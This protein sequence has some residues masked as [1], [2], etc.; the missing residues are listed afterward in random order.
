MKTYE[1]ERFKNKSD[2]K[3]FHTKFLGGT[4]AGVLLGVSKYKTKLDLYEEIV[5]NNTNENEIINENIT[6]GLKSEPLIRKMFALHFDNYKVRNPKGWECYI[7]K[8][9]P[10]LGATIDGELTDKETKEKGIL[11]IKTCDIRRKKDIEEWEKNIPMQYYCQVIHYLMIRTDCSF[12]KLVA[13]LRFFDWFV[14]LANKVTKL[15]T[16]IYHIERADVEEDIKKLKKLEIDF[17]KNNI[18][19]RIPPTFTRKIGG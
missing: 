5:A 7:D 9:Y 19:P 18:E 6:I 16:R 17:W 14:P 15:E 10:F 12:A 2:W 11:E 8:E 3:K 13:N 1:V 4:S